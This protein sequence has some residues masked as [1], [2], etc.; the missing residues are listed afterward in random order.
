MEVEDRF[1]IDSRKWECIEMEGEQLEEHSNL[2][3]ITEDLKET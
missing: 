2:N 3:F 1:G